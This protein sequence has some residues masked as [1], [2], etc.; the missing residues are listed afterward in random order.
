MA[1]DFDNIQIPVSYQHDA[2]TCSTMLYDSSTIHIYVVTLPIEIERNKLLDS[3]SM[4]YGW[5]W[6]DKQ[7]YVGLYFKKN[8][9]ISTLPIGAIQAMNGKWNPENF[10]KIEEI[11]SIVLSYCEHSIRE[12]FRFSDNL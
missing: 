9:D 1:E 7:E 2:I 8:Y 3:L 10:D 6:K 11:F 4:E 5:A 12:L